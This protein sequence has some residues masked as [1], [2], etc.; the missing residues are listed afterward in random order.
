MGNE[1]NETVFREKS[2]ERISSPD[3]LNDYVR[4]S[5][6]GVWFVLGAIM[7]ILLGACI[8]GIFGHIDSSVPAV[9]IS[10]DGKMVCLVKKEYGDRFTKDM[11]VKIDDAEYDVS[12]RD[13]K[14]VTV[15][16]TTDSYALFIGDMQPGEWVYEIDVDGSFS[17][18][19][20]EA[21]LITEKISP[22]S[23]IFNKQ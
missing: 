7:I 23:F 2:I 6:P 16:D 9:G 21:R 12:L 18:G 22:L 8:F 4:L 1:K 19:S 15:W 3:Q 14:P 13:P 17:D 10:S 20:Y 11:K 5:N